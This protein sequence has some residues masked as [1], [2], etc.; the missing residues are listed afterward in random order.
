MSKRHSDAIAIQGGAC[1]PRAIVNAIQRAITELDDESV[2]S[3]V[4]ASGNV[5][6]TR[7]VSADTPTICNDPAIRLMIHQLG[8]ITKS[9]DQYMALDVYGKLVD[10]CNEAIKVKADG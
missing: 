3:L 6:G 10:A 5:V 9:W 4:G 8:Y 2:Q 7:M 1:N